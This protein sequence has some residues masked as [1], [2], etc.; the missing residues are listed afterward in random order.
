MVECILKI[1]PVN[2]ESNEM[3]DDFSTSDLCNGLI[4]AGGWLNRWVALSKFGDKITNDNG[5]IILVYV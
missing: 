1:G 3:N 4:M 5:N 2:S